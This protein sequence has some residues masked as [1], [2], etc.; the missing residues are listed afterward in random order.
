MPTQNPNR[1]P[2]PRLAP[3]LLIALLAACQSPSSPDSDAGVEPDTGSA[4][5][6]VEVASTDV[7][8]A[9]VPTESLEA[10]ED[11]PDAPTRAAF[12]TAAPNP[13]SKGPVAPEL[14]SDTWL[15]SDPITM[16]SLRGEVVII[17]FWTYG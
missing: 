5:P 3:L 17:D 15:N 2:I 12:P 9:E 14:E 16:A 11:A 7:P 1:R 6:I 10:A 13:L 4:A 8:T